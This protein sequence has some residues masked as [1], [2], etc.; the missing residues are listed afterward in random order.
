MV[1][2]PLDQKPLKQKFSNYAL[3]WLDSELMKF[4]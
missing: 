1:G 3:G 2:I 4:K